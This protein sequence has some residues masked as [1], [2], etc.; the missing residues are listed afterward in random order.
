M[1]FNSDKFDYIDQ[2]NNEI[3]NILKIQ[4]NNDNSKPYLITLTGF[5]EKSFNTTSHIIINNSGKISDIFN[6][7]YIICVPKLFKNLQITACNK[8]DTILNNRKISLLTKEEYIQ[9]FSP[10]IE[11]N[12]RLAGYI[13][14]LIKNIIPP[15]KTI[16][17]LGK[18]AGAGVMIKLF[19]INHYYH[20][21]YLGVPA[22]P[23]NVEDIIINGRK[24]IIA[25]DKRD[26]YEFP[27]GK[28]NEEILSYKKTLEPSTNYIVEE[29]NDNKDYDTKKYHEIPDQLFD[30]IRINN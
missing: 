19:A 28:S 22:C 5:S 25:F 8:R 14:N 13:D 9:V 2:T 30:L 1:L 20:A 4:L 23:T 29:F 6:S 3:Y 11:L 18:C 16:H 10:E 7:I 24:I 27:W 21:L 17:L 26:A 15:Y 12:I